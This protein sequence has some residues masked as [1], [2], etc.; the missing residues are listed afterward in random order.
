MFSILKSEFKSI[1]HFINE[2]A[3]CNFL[4]IVNKTTLICHCML[5]N[6]VFV[7]F[8]FVSLHITIYI[9]SADVICSNSFDNAIFNY[10]LCECHLPLCVTLHVE[11]FPLLTVIFEELV[12]IE[13]VLHAISAEIKATRFAVIT[14]H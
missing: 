2:P 12:S 9:K 6:V 1:R 10:H 7:E 8:Y 3:A 4:A 14:L 11:T 13:T 5:I